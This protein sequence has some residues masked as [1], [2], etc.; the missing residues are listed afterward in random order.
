ML[1]SDAFATVAGAHPEFAGLSY[2][3][4][5]LGGRPIK[6]AGKGAAS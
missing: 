2:D 4:L 6:S 5:A 3:L 1:A